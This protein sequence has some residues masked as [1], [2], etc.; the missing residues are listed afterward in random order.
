MSNFSVFSL[1]HL[2]KVRDYIYHNQMYMDIEKIFLPAH[3]FETGWGVGWLPSGFW[4]VHIK[5]KHIRLLY[6]PFHQKIPKYLNNF[7]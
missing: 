3:C 1:L 2:L 5:L 7:N 6:T 4:K